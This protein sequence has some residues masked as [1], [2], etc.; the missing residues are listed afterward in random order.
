MTPEP[1]AEIHPSAARRAGVAS[2][3]RVTLAT[4]R[5]SA[6][7]KVRVTKTIR[8]DTVFL[9]FH[10]GGSQSANALT[11]PTLDP[12]SRMPEFKVSAARLT[13]ASTNVPA[14]DVD[15]DERGINS[16]EERMTLSSEGSSE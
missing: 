10:W 16:T 11:N 6:T 13:V 12:I 14:K 15:P 5:G 7:F 9:P 4:R 2:G 8:E 3:D 1:L